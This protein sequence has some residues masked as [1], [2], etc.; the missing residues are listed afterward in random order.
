[1]EKQASDLLNELPRPIAD[2]VEFAIYT[3]FRKENILSLKIES[4]NFGDDKTAGEVN[5]VTK[6]KKTETYPLCPPAI[7]VIIRAKNNR[8]SGYTF[9]N[10][11]TKTRYVSINKTVD[12]CIRKLNLSVNGS[13]FRIHD[14]RHVFA[15]WLHK[16]GASLD[17]IRPLM[18]HNDRS[19]TD[20]YTTIDMQKAGKVLQFMPN[21]RKKVSA[22]NEPKP[23][24]KTADTY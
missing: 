2:I 17:D 23:S 11:K 19:T 15:T 1:M 21:I 22:E 16:S 9:L 5:L 4:V 18:G 14:L 10:P 24:I 8:E 7:Q 20:R 12:R 3:G 6:G 13:K